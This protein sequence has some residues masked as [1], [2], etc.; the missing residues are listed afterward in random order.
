M[1]SNLYTLFIVVL[2]TL[3]IILTI[4][5]FYIKKS[6]HQKEKKTEIEQKYNTILKQKKENYFF[7]NYLIKRK[8]YSVRNSFNCPS[9]CSP[10][11]DIYNYLQR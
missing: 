3:V 5:Y 11:H 8:K 1:G 2:N 4:T 6:N 10:I 7:L 9:V